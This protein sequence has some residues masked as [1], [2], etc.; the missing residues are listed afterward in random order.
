MNNE[1][2]PMS[3]TMQPTFVSVDEEVLRTALIAITNGLETTI[4][5]LADHDSYLGR[6]T[7]KNENWAKTLES[8]IRMMTKSKEQLRKV[9][10]FDLHK[11]E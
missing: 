11:G 1:T 3:Q 10:K 8:D 6:S 2:L 9:L 5:C 4:S 7:R